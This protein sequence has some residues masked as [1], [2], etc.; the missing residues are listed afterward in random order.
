MKTVLIC[1]DNVFSEVK[2]G[3]ARTVWEMVKEFSRR[4]YKVILFVRGFNSPDERSVSENVVIYRHKNNIFRVYKFLSEIFFSNKISFVNF[5]DPLTSFFTLI[6]IKVKGFKFKII[7]TFQSPWNVEY[8]IRADKKKVNWSWK[9]LN[10]FIR[11]G[12]EKYCL[13][14]SDKI[15]VASKYMQDLLFKIHRLSSEIMPLGVDTER[16]SP[17]D[18]NTRNKIR[19]RFGISHSVKLFFTLRNLEPR[20]G[21][22]NLVKAV[23]ILKNKGFKNIF[24]IIGGNGTLFNELSKMI[25]ELGLK[26]YIVLTGSIVDEELVDYYRMADAFILP[27]RELEGF[28][29]VSIE[30]MACGVPVLATPVSANIEVVGGFDKSFLFNGVSDVDIAEG[31]EAFLKRNDLKEISLN[32]RKYVEENYSWKK[33]VDRIEKLIEV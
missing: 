25:D 27:T 4:K 21:L 2:G 32:V 33:Y 16:F 31:I 12:V 15:I 18:F 5:H 9:F 7:Y 17:V 13:K 26:N 29:L 28:G 11:K 8:L 14:N 1:G 19:D 20:M 30:A 24:F 22:K 3:A 10:S 6:Y 23:Y